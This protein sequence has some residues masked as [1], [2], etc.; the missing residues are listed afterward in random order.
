MAKSNPDLWQT[1]KNWLKDFVTSFA[2]RVKRAFSGIT[3][4]SE[5]A[6]ALT[7]IRDGVERYVWN[8]QKI[9]DN[10][11]VEA[12][13]RETAE[14]TTEKKGDVV[15]EREYQERKYARDY[16]GVQFDAQVRAL[17]NGEMHGDGML[18]LGRTPKELRDIGLSD[19]PIMMD[20]EHAKKLREGTTSS[21]IDDH[22][23]SW[24]TIKKLP[25]HITD[26]VAVILS[27]DE[28]YRNKTINVIIDAQSKSGRQ[29]F[30]AIQLDATAKDGDDRID[31]NKASTLFGS[32]KIV[33]MF[34][35]A[36]AKT[37]FGERKFFI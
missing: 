30:M 9:W 35:E 16:Y 10:A 18:L 14:E 2:H 5:E 17:I 28:K 6:Q 20:M 32:E 34:N 27:S 29:V 15:E 19:L 24:Q 26:P 8:I 23:L 4:T 25:E 21:T 12:A 33:Q 31:I 7:E 1:M 11:L 22:I 37:S 13:G 3:A 36:V